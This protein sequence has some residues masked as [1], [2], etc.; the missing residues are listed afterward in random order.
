METYKV[1]CAACHMSDGSGVPNVQPSLRHSPVVNSEVEALVQL[2]LE[3]W[4]SGEYANRM[5]SFAHLDDEAITA[6]LTY[7]RTHFGNQSRPVNEAIVRAVRRD[8]DK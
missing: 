2:T 8:I 5:P 6:V 3:G 1:R 7:T 4:V